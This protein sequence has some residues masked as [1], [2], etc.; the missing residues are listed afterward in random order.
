MTIEPSKEA[1][2]VD[3][4]LDVIAASMHRVGQVLP[5]IYDRVNDDQL[6]QDSG[7]S[8]LQL[9][10]L[11]MLSHNANL[12]HL[13]LAKLDGRSIENDPVVDRLIQGC[14]QRRLADS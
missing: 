14:I 11:V 13:I 12:L 5:Q 1:T 6:Q 10:N 8:L 9:K 3:S 7:L 2:R 4:K